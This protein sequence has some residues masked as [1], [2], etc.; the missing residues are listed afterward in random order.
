MRRKKVEKKI[1]AWRSG[2]VTG[3]DDRRWLRRSGS[4]TEGCSE[5]LPIHKRV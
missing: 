5:A 4:L 1:A 2:C 3:K